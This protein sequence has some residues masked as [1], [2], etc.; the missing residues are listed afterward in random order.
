MRTV[1]DRRILSVML[2]SLMVYKYIF[3]IHLLS[4]CRSFLAHGFVS[5]STDFEV[6]SAMTGYPCELLI[7]L[8][9]MLFLYDSVSMIIIMM[10]F[11]MMSFSIFSPNFSYG[12]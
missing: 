3:T 9:A 6:V 11:R 1:F 4:E 7:N 5:V 8:S 10:L 12:L 2:F